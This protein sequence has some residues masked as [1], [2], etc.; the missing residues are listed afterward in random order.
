MSSPFLLRAHHPNKNRQTKKTTPPT[1]TTPHK[2]VFTPTDD[3]AFCWKTENEHHDEKRHSCPTSGIKAGIEAEWNKQHRVG[4]GL[5]SCTGSYCNRHRSKFC[6]R[7]NC[8]WAVFKGM[9]LM[10]DSHGATE[11]RSHQFEIN[12]KLRLSW[13]CKLLEVRHYQKEEITALHKMKSLDLPE[14]Q[15]SKKQ[16]RELLCVES[17]TN[18]SK[19]NL[20]PIAEWNSYS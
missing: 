20:P 19:K 17:H 8:G 15:I 16:Q 9:Y 14:H 12:E 3:P 18:F 4:L 7:R 2:P 10:Q 13:R 6:R 5:G 1:K 11:D